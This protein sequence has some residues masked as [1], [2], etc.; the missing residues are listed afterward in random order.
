MLTSVTEYPG[1]EHWF[2]DQ[3]VDWPPLFNFF[4]WHQLPEDSM[5][6]NIDFTTASPGISADYHWVSILQQLHPLQYS[7][8]QLARD[9]A[10]KT[11]I[12]STENIRLLKLALNDFDVDSDIK[13]TLDNTSVDYKIKTNGDSIFLKRENNRWML[14]AGPDLY[15]KNP[16]RYGTF[17]EAFNHRMIFVYGTDGSKEENELNLNKVKYD[18]E[19]WYYRGNGSV[20]IIADKEYSTTKYAGRNVIIYGNAN[21]NSAWNVLLAGCPIQVNRNGIKVGNESFTG[22]DLGT[23]FVWPI[24]NSIITSVGVIS[25]TG[26]EGMN[27]ANANQYFAGASGFPD[28]MIFRLSMLQSGAGKVEMAGFFDNDWKLTKADSVKK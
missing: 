22:D 18:A 26:V 20:D 27:A 8:I 14:D 1:G 6:N 2:G 10:K 15:E 19:T 5:V 25:G 21:T 23:Y 7:K 12:G 11:I 13:I 17:K 3:S 28:F 24:K 16:H 4:K 9:R